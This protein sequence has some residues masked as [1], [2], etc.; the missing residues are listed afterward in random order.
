MSYI[1]GK[2]LSVQKIKNEEKI[3]VE[4]SNGVTVIVSNKFPYIE[5]YFQFP[6]IK[7]LLCAGDKI[8]CEVLNNYSTKIPM[9]KISLDQKSIIEYFRKSHKTKLLEDVYLDVNKLNKECIQ[10]ETKLHEFWLKKFV[11]RQLHLLGLNDSDIV[12]IRKNLIEFDTLLKIIF[13][14]P[15]KIFC[16]DRNKCVDIGKRLYDTI[17]L[18]KVQR[19][20]KYR[21]AAYNVYENYEKN[22]MVFTSLK[23]LNVD[24]DGL[25]EYLMVVEEDRV[26]IPRS[27]YIET[28]LANIL[29]EYMNMDITININY[30]PRSDLSEL[31]N[32]AIENALRFPIT[33]I[34]G[35]AGTGKSTLIYNIHKIF[36]IKRIYHK[37]VSFTGKSV[38]RLNEIGCNSM[39]IHR[40]IF[41]PKAENY[42]DYLIIDEV[43]MLSSL[44]FYELVKSFKIHYKKYPRLIL[45]GD[46]NQ[47]EPTET[48]FLINELLK[49]NEKAK[50]KIPLVRLE[51][52]YRSDD[53][54]IKYINCYLN[55]KIHPDIEPIEGDL[56]ELKELILRFSGKPIQ[57]FVIISPRS[58]DLDDVNNMCQ[59]LLLNS[60]NKEYIHKNGKIFK[61]G[62]KVINTKNNYEHNVMNGEEGIIKDIREDHIEVKL[63]TGRIVN[64]QK[65]YKKS[66]KRDLVTK[67]KSS[68]LSSD[69]DTSENLCVDNLMHSYAITC[70]KSQGSEWKNV[71]VYCPSYI[72]NFI[73][74]NL[75]YTAMSRAKEKIYLI[76]KPDIFYDSLNCVREYKYDFLS[77]R[78]LRMVDCN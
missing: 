46:P 60:N 31:Q 45:V 76:G 12:K 2:I 33:I 69:T 39:T 64:F 65:Q 66:T 10:C 22:K 26:Y 59:E 47:L 44:L 25:K 1:F 28:N 50:R 70:H 15:F 14:N 51:K 73:T 36:N 43:S 68:L 77:E 40:F 16:L 61:V 11:L 53:I 18:N 56:F 58:K 27:Y 8:L 17:D 67:L 42:L 74:K 9:V 30:V 78:L 49:Y 20:M 35:N 34:L 29:Y 48:G 37:V 7:T 55:G 62:D 54:I 63:N 23:D 75:I 24:A 57:D 21:K 3:E 13:E 4:T 38:S 32:I 41:S 5:R 52:C 6:T 71:I 19:E 72:E